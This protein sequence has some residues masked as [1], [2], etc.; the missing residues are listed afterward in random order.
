MEVL[1]AYESSSGQLVNKSKS[2]IYLHHLTDNEV[3]NKVERITGIG[4]QC[5]P[6]TYLG[7]PIFYARRRSD[8][9][10]G[11]ITKVMDKMQSW[12]GKLLS[13]GGR[14]VLIANA[15]QSIP[16]HMLSAV[17]PSIYV[18]NKLHSIF[19]KFFWR[20]NVGGNSRHWSSWTNLCMPYEEGGIGFRSLHDVSKAL[21]CKLWWNFRKK[22]SL[23]TA[24]ISQKYC[25]K[26][27]SV[28]VPW[29]LP[30][31]FGIDEDIHNV[32]DLVEN[33]MWNLEKI[34][35]TLPEDLVNHIVQNIR[36]PNECAELDT[37]LWMLEI[38][39]HF[40]VKSAWDYLR[41]RDNPRLTYKMI[42]VKGLPFNISFFLWKVWKAKLS[43]DDF[44]PRSVWNYFLRR[45]GIALQG[46]SLQQ[47]ITKCWT[48]PV[49]PKLKPI[50]QALPVCIVWELWKRRNSLKYGDVV[51]GNRVI[52]Q[53]SSTIQALVK[54]RKPGIYVPHKWQ[55]LLHT[56]ENYVPKLRWEKVL[57]E[58]PS[59]GWIKANTDGASRGNPSRS[60]IGIVLRDEFGD[61]RYATGREIK[62]GSNNEAEATALV[63]AIR[64]CR[65]MNFSNIWLQ[66]DSLM[67]KNIID[68]LWKPP[69]NIVDV[70][71]EII[72]LKEGC[73]FKISHIF[74]EGNKLADHLA[75]Y[76][77]DSGNI[78]SFNFW[79]LDVSSR[80]MDQLNNLSMT[81]VSQHHMH[82]HHS[83]E[84]K[85]NGHRFLH[86]TLV[87]IGIS[88]RNPRKVVYVG[89]CEH[90]VTWERAVWKK[91]IGIIE[92]V[93]ANS[94][95]RCTFGT[96]KR[97]LDKCNG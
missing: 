72:S 6:M 78:E 41:R 31:E 63:E 34:F 84:S 22:P 81:L 43:L 19:A 68:G 9:Y 27:N 33:G 56:L 66:T 77:L 96:L 87:F 88:E 80:R 94:T 76:A 48:A 3:I 59:N 20:S 89:G 5:F 18:I 67:L 82:Q 95:A 61:I 32:N 39:G 23:W 49:V 91:V 38:R 13:V 86:C 54:I 46:L 12:K 69:W 70:V 21:F 71:E 2:A 83:R 11:L 65:A 75:N 93:I 29:K 1:Q 90:N 36:P 44:L 17:N 28:I 73:N 14:A 35:Q 74:R 45:A 42:W 40:S 60:A 16:I 25:K 47:A 30:V 51:S 52:Y 53:V 50:M 92:R 57:W 26:L 7:C 64:M 62:E 8:Y 10:Q 55:D 15:M 85:S 97:K 58:H 79:E 4:R 24:F 37:P